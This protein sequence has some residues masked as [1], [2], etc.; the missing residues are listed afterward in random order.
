MRVG[1]S[2]S[3]GERLVEPGRRGVQRQPHVLEQH[4]P[5]QR[6]AV[7]VEPR[8]RQAEQPSPG[9]MVAPVHAGGR[10]DDAD[11]EPGQVVLAVGVEAGQ[12]GGLAADQRA[13][14]L[15]AAVGDAGDHP[16]GDADVELAGGE[17]VE[18]EQRLGAGHG[19]VVDAHR[20]QVD[21]DRVVAPGQEREL[22][23]GA[24]A[25]GARH[26]QRLAVARGMAHRPAKPPRL[27]H[28]LGAAACGGRAP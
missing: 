9:R 18:E 14:G 17:V 28:H 19:H 26:Q 25:V 12:L 10:L 13:A 22:Q 6:V 7:R 8:R 27:A 1:R 16:L 20:D 23:L 24:D 5:H 4:P 3:A 21:A 15:L 2:R 11:A